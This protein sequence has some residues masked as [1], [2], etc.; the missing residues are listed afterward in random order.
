M[1]SWKPALSLS[2]GFVTGPQGCGRYGCGGLSRKQVL[3]NSETPGTMG[4][5]QIPVGCIR[6]KGA[7]I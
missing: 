7:E 5:S 2:K 6:K 1:R 4:M 3:D